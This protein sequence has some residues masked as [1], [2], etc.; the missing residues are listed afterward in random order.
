MPTVEADDLKVHYLE[1]G[2]GEPIVFVH[3]N[4]STSSWWEPVLE[5]LPEGYRGIAYDVRGRGRTEGPDSEYTMPELAADL[6]ALADALDLDRFH[7][8]GHSLGSAIAMQFAL[9]YPDRVRSLTV[10]APAWVDGMPDAYNVPAGQEAIKADKSLFE[11]AL[12]P[13]AP[14]VEEGEFWRRLVDE[15]FEQRL[16]A[17]LKNLDALSNWKPGD[18]LREIGAPT[19]VISGELDALTGAENAVRAIEALGAEHRVID[20][21]G[22]SPNIEAPE[23][24]VGLLVAHI[25]RA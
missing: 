10:I 11:Q 17:A 4:W 19:L 13:L 24:F 1:E 14:T 6:A 22:H 5:R 25:S 7:L 3:G 23:A 18:Q 2:E 12:K 9:E 8:V 21:V 16:T 15:G 20:K